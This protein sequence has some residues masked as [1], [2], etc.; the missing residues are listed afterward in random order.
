MKGFLKWLVVGV[1]AAIAYASISPKSYAVNLQNNSTITAKAKDNSH[2]ISYDFQKQKTNLTANI[3]IK[4]KNIETTITADYN[5]D[6]IGAEVKTEHGYATQAV[7]NDTKNNI[8]IE[9]TKHGLGIGGVIHPDGDS[10]KKQKGLLAGFL[11]KSSLDRYVDN[12][13]V[14]IPLSKTKTYQW[15]LAYNTS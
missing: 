13:Y 1:V 14:N 6:S 2:S 3:A 4:D 8:S 9:G 10:P 15:K 12:I 7:Y 5:N 11:Q